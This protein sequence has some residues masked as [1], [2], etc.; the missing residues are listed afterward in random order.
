MQSVPASLGPQVL[1]VALRLLHAGAV[2]EAPPLSQPAHD[3]VNLRWVDGGCVTRTLVASHGAR[4]QHAWG[5][6]RQTAM[7]VKPRTGEPKLL[8][9]KQLAEVTQPGGVC[10]APPLSQPA[11]DRGNLACDECCGRVVRA[12]ETRPPQGCNMCGAARMRLHAPNLPGQQLDQVTQPEG[13]P[14]GQPAQYD[15]E[16]GDDR[17][18]DKQGHDKP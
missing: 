2:C 10:E 3:S 4:L 13:P 14:L 1:A 15:V 5:S 11:H 6:M 7:P 18:H 16:Q 12:L 9:P 8:G 17:S